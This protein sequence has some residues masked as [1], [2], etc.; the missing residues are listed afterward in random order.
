MIRSFAAAG[1]VNRVVAVFDNDTAAADGLRGIS[2]RDFPGQI[3]IIRYPTLELAKRYPTL[4]P[5]TLE[6]PDGS[7]SVADVNGRAGSIEL[8]LGSDVLTRKDGTLFPVQWTSFIAGT[9]Q[10]QGEVISKNS[11]H[12]RFREKYSL[13]LQDPVAFEAQDWTGL[14]LILD[15]ICI[16]AASAF[17]GEHQSE[18]L[19]V[20]LRHGK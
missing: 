8:Y 20:Q 2:Q 17:G 4:G 19:V 5:P 3:Q 16:T 13:A 14:K 15:A 1:I 12:E 18:T 11:I 7:F 10:Y 6:S 9:G